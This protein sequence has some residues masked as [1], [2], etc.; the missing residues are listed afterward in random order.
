M[1]YSSGARFSQYI[2]ARCVR[3]RKVEQRFRIDRET[4]LIA[5]KKLQSWNRKKSKFRSIIIRRLTSYLSVVID[6]KKKKKKEKAKST[7]ED[8]ALFETVYSR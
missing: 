3:D 6:S 2:V 8:E 5:A 4:S 1:R 7:E